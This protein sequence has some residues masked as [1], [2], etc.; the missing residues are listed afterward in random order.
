[1]SPR[2]WLVLAVL[3]GACGSETSESP[4]P[5]TASQE[6]VTGEST[7]CER[8]LA[9]EETRAALAEEVADAP[10]FDREAYLERCNA[11]P[12]S[13]Q[14]CMSASYAEAHAEEC[15]PPTFPTDVAGGES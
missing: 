12:V 10:S 6:S 9:E 2:G 5:Q 3:L 1:M 14:R 15:A 7:P 13:A 4:A 11:E 8:A